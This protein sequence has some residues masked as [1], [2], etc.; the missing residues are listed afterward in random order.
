VLR[1]ALVPYKVCHL[2]I[3]ADPDP[4]NQFD[5]DPDSAYHFDADPDPGSV[6]NLTESS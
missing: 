5:T 4:A 1:E 6:Q 2:E 3:D